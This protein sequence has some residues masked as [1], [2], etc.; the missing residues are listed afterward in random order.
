MLLKLEGPKL[1]I[2]NT[3]GSKIAQLGNQN[4]NERPKKNL[5]QIIY[6][7]A[8]LENRLFILIN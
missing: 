4:C 8:D 3:L 5:N 7:S 6:I 1:H 2:L